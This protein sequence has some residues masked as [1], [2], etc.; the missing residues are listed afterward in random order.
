[1]VILGDVQ[2]KGLPRLLDG[3]LRERWMVTE[4]FPQGTLEK[5]Y[6]KYKGNALLALKAFLSLLRTVKPLHETNIVHRDIKPA[7]V[8]IRSDEELVL[9]DFGIVYI[10]GNPQRLTKTNETVGPHDYMPP[11]ADF[12][13]RIE[14][15]HAS[16]D[17]YMLGKL[18]WCMVSGRLRL[19]R[20]WFN[21][22]EYDL[23][24]IFKEEPYM[25]FINT[26]L[27][28]CLVEEAKQ[29]VTSVADLCLIVETYIVAMERGGQVIRDGVSRPFR[30]CGSGFYQ[31]FKINNPVTPLTLRL[32]VGSGPHDVTSFGIRLFACDRC[33]HIQWFSGGHSS[34]S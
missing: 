19:P 5:Q 6:A 18:L 13:E 26:I 30:V 2:W 8:F 25:H 7:N 33:G 11:W 14:D 1:M 12:G 16:F 9:G 23:T 31:E 22:P 21:R 24:V 3:N 17:V 27:K 10:P 20:E 34:V 32:W 28:R 15:V 4:Y 29:C